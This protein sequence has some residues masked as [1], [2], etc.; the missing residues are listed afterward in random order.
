MGQHF[1]DVFSQQTEQLI[2][3]GC[4]MQFSVFHENTAGGVVDF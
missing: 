3:D 2:F 4:Q 1:P